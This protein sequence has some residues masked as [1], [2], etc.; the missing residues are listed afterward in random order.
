MQKNFHALRFKFIQLLNADL[1][2]WKFSVKKLIYVSDGAGGQYKNHLNFTNLLM[3]QIDFG[4]PAEWHFFATSHG[5]G[6][7][8]AI[9]DVVKRA[10]RLESLKPK[11]HILNS[12]DLFRFCTRDLASDKL[13]FFYVS[14]A[15]VE[16]I[17]EPFKERYDSSR[18]IP[19]TRSF[20]SFVPVSSN[21][22]ELRILSSS[23]KHTIGVLNTPGSGS[24]EIKLEPGKFLAFKVDRKR[25]VGQLLIVD[26]K[27][28]D[29]EVNFMK[30]VGRG[31]RLR[32]PFQPV[33][34]YLPVTSAI[35][36]IEAPNPTSDGQ[37]YTMSQNDY[38]LIRIKITV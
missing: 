3:H 36:N 15:E 35:C 4:I 33:S 14:R 25:Q 2:S 5:K 29:V 1:Q 7:C 30:R 10:G 21:Q 38:D 24:T 32:W 12:E 20:H 18:T 17:N 11:R 6:T 13:V 31:N 16:S 37:Q 28:Q 8:D 27:T 9:T 26:E 23:L 22:L 34:S 19:G